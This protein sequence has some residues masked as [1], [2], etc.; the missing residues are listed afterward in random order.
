MPFEPR[1]MDRLVREMVAKVKNGFHIKDQWL[2]EKV[3]W[4]SREISG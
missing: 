3:G 4:L 1:K 2:N